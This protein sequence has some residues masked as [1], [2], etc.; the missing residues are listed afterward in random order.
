MSTSVVYQTLG[1]EGASSWA[2]PGGRR[3]PSTRCPRTRPPSLRRAGRDRAPAWAGV[4]SLLLTVTTP[5]N[6]RS[7][8]GHRNQQ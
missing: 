3:W 6:N 8:S 4:T 5:S 7:S 1:P 2:P